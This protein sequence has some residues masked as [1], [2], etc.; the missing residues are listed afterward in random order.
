ML[1]PTGKKIFFFRNEKTKSLN[2]YSSYLRY[3][4]RL[5]T[6]DHTFRVYRNVATFRFYQKKKKEIRD[7]WDQSLMTNKNVSL[8]DK[9]FEKEVNN[10]IK[11]K[12]K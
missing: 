4:Y 5:K 3:R 2:I 11:F 1:F 12:G 6:M 9:I 10:Y 7:T 8:D